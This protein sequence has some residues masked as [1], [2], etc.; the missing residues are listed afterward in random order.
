[1]LSARGR[2]S[3]KTK[4]TRGDPST[5]G[6][7]TGHRPSVSDD[8]IMEALKATAG[9]IT[10]ASDKLSISQSAVSARIKRTPRIQ[11]LLSDIK[12]G[13]LD[14]SEIQ[15]LKCIKSKD[16][17]AIKY[18]L[19]SQGKDR[20]YGKHILIDQNTRL[21]GD[22]DNPLSIIMV[23]SLDAFKEQFPI[24]I[25]EPKEETDEEEAE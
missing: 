13:H 21:S 15:L 10:Q 12:A 17:G 5:P 9:F 16:I 2:K 23:P 3:L 18:Y 4:H 20:G 7:S 11:E 6:K 24:E 1:M 8:Q 22:P 19:D 14:F 25:E